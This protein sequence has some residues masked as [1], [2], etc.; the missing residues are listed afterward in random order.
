[1]TSDASDSF[2]AARP[3]RR[4]AL[5]TMLKVLLTM[6]AWGA[7]WCWVTVRHDWEGDVLFVVAPGHGIH[8]HD[9]LGL[10][11]PLLVTGALWWKD[12]LN[13]VRATRHG[14]SRVS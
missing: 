1:M 4:P 8:S 2:D 13:L 7:G 11:V 5:I 14:R 6:A 10:A 12:V 9:W 3:D